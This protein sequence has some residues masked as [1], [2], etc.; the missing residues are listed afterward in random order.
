[1]N[2]CIK[3]IKTFRSLLEKR[4]NIISERDYTKAFPKKED[5][6]KKEKWK[7]INI[8]VFWII[9][10]LDVFYV[11]VFINFLIFMYFT[12]NKN[13]KSYILE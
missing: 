4:K 8:F 7:N 13:L 1:M 11:F 10:I 5:K 2:E 9:T 3:K 6:K 12:K